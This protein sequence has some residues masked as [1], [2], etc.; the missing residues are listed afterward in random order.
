MLYN[1]IENK[2]NFKNYTT[3]HAKILI[4]LLKV[5]KWN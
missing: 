2:S 5:I 1:Y 3:A 4:Y